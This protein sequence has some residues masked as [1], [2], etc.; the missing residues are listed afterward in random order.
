MKQINLFWIKE[1]WK[2][3]VIILLLIFVLFQCESSKQP[4][5]TNVYKD[6][7]KKFHQKARQIIDNSNDIIK[8]YK[9]VIK[10]K[11]TEI[12]KLKKDIVNN[13][14]I[15]NDKL[16]DLK[17]Y[18]TSDIS[19]YYIDRYNQPN[20]I[21]SLSANELVIKDTLNRFIISDLINFDGVKFDYKVLKNMYSLE[22]EKFNSANT[23]IDTLKININNI[24]SAYENSIEQNKLA[25]KEVEKQLKK[26]KSK[27]T[28]YKITTVAAIIGGGYLL[29]K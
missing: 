8:D 6:N 21:K 22:N 10:K 28:L 5:L 18:N 1:N 20:A 12:S 4:S 17:R 7:A 26:E 19:K 24:S 11:D 9:D 13:S 25:I 29:I 3:L 16:N 27:K 14:K 23:T 2:I 15:I